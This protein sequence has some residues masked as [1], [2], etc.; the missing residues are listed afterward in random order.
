MTET[1]VEAHD[2]SARPAEF[3]IAEIVSCVSMKTS[4]IIGDVFVSKDEARSLLFHFRKE[5]AHEGADRPG[6]DSDGQGW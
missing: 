4:P 6:E 1:R 3:M 5:P 2:A